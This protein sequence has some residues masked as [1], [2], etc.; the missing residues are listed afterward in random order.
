MMRMEVLA[1]LGYRM[2]MLESLL[3]A[4]CCCGLL[5]LRRGFVCLCSYGLYS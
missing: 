3:V 1:A 2:D 4:C 5:G